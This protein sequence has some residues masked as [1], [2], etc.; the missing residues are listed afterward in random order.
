MLL[1]K[2]QEYGIAVIKPDG[3]KNNVLPELLFDINESYLK[4]IGAKITSLKKEDVLSNF[5]TKFDLD[6]YAM[7]LSSDNLIVLLV[8]GE[9]APYILRKI[10]L[11]MRK[12]YGL[13][14]E[15]MENLVHTVDPGSEYFY[16]FK[17]FFPELNQAT[18]STFADLNFI[19]KSQN[20]E[21]ILKKLLEIERETNLTYLGYIVN[22]NYSSN[23]ILRFYDCSEIQSMKILL[24]LKQS[25]YISNTLIYL[26]GYLPSYIA[27]LPNIPTY[28]N[29]DICSFIQWVKDLGGFT[30]LDY[31]PLKN[32]NTGMLIG[33]KEEGM[34]GAMV[35][36]PRRSLNEVIQLEDII[37]S[38]VGLDF[39][40]GSAGI[41]DAA[42]LSIGKRDFM[43]LTNNLSMKIQK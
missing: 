31:I 37:E 13:T 18:Y 5:Y 32:I 30:V 3:V 7:Y 16:Q 8:H 35:Y 2:N 38:E 15:N 43:K 34:A 41:V 33:L 20:E 9:N 27:K 26:I 14:S 40:G 39:A 1:P 10:K 17:L 6:S 23:S 42:E 24:G 12:K 29:Y 4:I 11:K 19:F 25:F 21:V 28:I 22:T 36:D